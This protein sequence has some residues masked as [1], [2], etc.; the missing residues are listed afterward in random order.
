MLAT[1][2]YTQ[3]QINQFRVNAINYY[4]NQYG[5]DFSQG[6]HNTYLD[7]YNFPYAGMFPYAGGRDN[8]VHLEFDSKNKHRGKDGNW[9]GYQFGEVVGMFSNG[10]F[11]G[12]VMN[13]TSYQAGDLL[14]YFNY[15]FVQLTHSNNH[16]SML[17]YT[18]WPTKQPVNSFGK[19]E[20]FSKMEVVDSEGNIGFFSEDIHVLVNPY[21]RTDAK[22]KIRGVFTFY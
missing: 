10:T 8:T 20:S 12:G 4:K 13:G 2:R 14:A 19:I 17:C 5:I 18:P 21:N 11:T 15:D 22:M 16:E 7:S 6:I 3:S 9:Y 1:G